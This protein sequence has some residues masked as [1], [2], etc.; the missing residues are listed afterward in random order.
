M[1]EDEV[2]GWGKPVDDLFIF[3]MGDGPMGTSPCP[4]TPTYTLP[5]DTVTGHKSYKR[6]NDNY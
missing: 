6:K 3:D 4:D 2:G 5:K 1:V